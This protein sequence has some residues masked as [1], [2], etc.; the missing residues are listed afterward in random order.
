MRVENEPSIE[1]DEGGERGAPVARHVS[2]EEQVNKDFGRV[3]RQAERRSE[4]EEERKDDT[5]DRRD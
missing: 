4:R 2:L 5:R 1:G 3:L